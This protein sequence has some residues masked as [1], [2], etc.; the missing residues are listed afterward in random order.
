MCLHFEFIHAL[1]T[2]TSRI[3]AGMIVSSGV[4]SWSSDRERDMR[5]AGTFPVPIVCPAHPSSACMHE[6]S[7]VSSHVWADK[8]RTI[9]SRSGSGFIV[10]IST[11]APMTMA[12]R[13]PL[14]KLK[15]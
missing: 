13:G 15:R 4:S 9:Y 7:G 8:K 5:E 11:C 2:P 10:P 1:R 12:V 3:R 14:L 6:V